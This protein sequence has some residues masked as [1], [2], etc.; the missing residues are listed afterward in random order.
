MG[1]TNMAENK[2]LRVGQKRSK[3][4]RLEPFDVVVLILATIAGFI[5]IYPM[6]NVIVLSISDPVAAAGGSIYFWP[7]GFYTG[8]YT[9]IL[10]EH[11]FWIALR[12]SVGYV[13]IGTILMLTTTVLVAYPL[14]RPNLKGRRACVIFLLIPMYFCGGMIPSFILITKLG[15]Y[16]TPW[17]TILPASYGIWNIILCKT[18]LQSIPHELAEAAYIDGAGNWQALSR[19]YLPLSK[20]VLAVIS[21]YT[22]VGIWN[23]WFGAKLYIPNKDIQPVQLYLQ[24]VLVEQSV[25][26]TKM[27]EMNM[28]EEMIKALSA[29]A[30]SARQLKYSM[31]VVV[32]LP[33]LLVYPMFQK[34]FVKGVMLGSLKG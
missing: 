13:V 17:S 29:K 31:I 20:P 15:L 19:I 2:A 24:R 33:I 9:V 22:I 4:K 21:I 3:L 6:W 26:M 30:L 10:R 5:T 11:D 14:T 8:S 16:N 28:T 25:D 7:V 1:V 12:N 18:F 23:S 32:T 27:L 34:H